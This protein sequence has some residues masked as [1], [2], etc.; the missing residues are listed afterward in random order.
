M[1]P[2]HTLA[3]GDQSV[4]VGAGETDDT[5]LI[6]ELEI[7]DDWVLDWF[8]MYIRKLYTFQLFTILGAMAHGEQLIGTT[9]MLT[10]SLNKRSP[11]S[12]TTPES[13][14][15]DLIDS[16]YVLNLELCWNDP[17]AEIVGLNV[18]V[19]TMKYSAK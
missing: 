17:V 13:F 16:S 3:G 2:G 4:H 11:R 7:S 18:A 6:P 1:K 9:S 5:R 8:T 19:T 12:N 15:L 10:K 14:S